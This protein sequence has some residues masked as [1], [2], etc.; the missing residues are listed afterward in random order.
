[1]KQAITP[2]TQMQA[3]GKLKKLGIVSDYRQMDNG[4]IEA[5]QSIQRSTVF[6]WSAMA[7]MQQTINDLK[8]EVAELTKKAA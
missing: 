5:F 2:S 3:M 7:Q 4:K 8:S 6:E 1:M